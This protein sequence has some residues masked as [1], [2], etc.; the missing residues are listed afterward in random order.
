MN[1]VFFYL[2]IVFGSFVVQGIFRHFP[3]TSIRLDLIGILVLFISFHVPTFPGSFLVLLLGL[4][5]ETLGAP[6]HGPLVLSYLILYFF[7]RLARNH[8]LF[9]RGFQQVMWVFILSLFQRMMEQGLLAW[10][11]EGSFF[12]LTNSLLSAG[13]QSFGSFFFF[14]FMERRIQMEKGSL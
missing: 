4:A 3:L 1:K 14:S 5:Q 7:I 6:F 9:D 8:L 2:A 12:N 10:L 11:H 13:L